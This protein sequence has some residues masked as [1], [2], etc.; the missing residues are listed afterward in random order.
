MISLSRI[1]LLSRAM[2]SLVPG[3]LVVGTKWKYR[4]IERLGIDSKH[5][6]VV[7]KAEVLSGPESNQPKWYVISRRVIVNPKVDSF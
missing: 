1:S 3:K 2:S 6:S 4:M 7:F 5:Q